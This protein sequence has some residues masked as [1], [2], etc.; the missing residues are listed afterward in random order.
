ML[1]AGAEKPGRDN[2]AGG[3]VGG[4]VCWAN[5]MTGSAVGPGRGV[6]FISTSLRQTWVWAQ[7]LDHV[8]RVLGQEGRDWWPA[9]YRGRV[10]AQAVDIEI[11]VDPAHAGLVALAAAGY[12]LYRHPEV[13]WGHDTVWGVPVA[14]A[15]DPLPWTPPGLR[16]V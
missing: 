13:T 4:S 8:K 16:E 15:P 9:R 12:T 7:D 10:Q 3:G 11:G 5:A 14:P 1:V 6:L 2:V